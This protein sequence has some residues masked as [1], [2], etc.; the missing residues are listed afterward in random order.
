MKKLEL[1]KFL[2]HQ[3]ESKML[4]LSSKTFESQNCSAKVSFYKQS[5]VKFCSNKNICYLVQ[6]FT[7]QLIISPQDYAQSIIVGK[8]SR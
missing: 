7:L 6:N 1:T 4:Y 3:N 8:E 2:V 5:F